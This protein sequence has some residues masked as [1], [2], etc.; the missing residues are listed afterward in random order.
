MSLIETN[1]DSR[2]VLKVLQERVSNQNLPE[3]YSQTSRLCQI[4]MTP[5]E[6]FFSLY[7]LKRN[8]ACLFEAYNLS[9]E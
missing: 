5:G 1:G 4:S 7:S 3:K 6:V 9:T 2:G 8:P